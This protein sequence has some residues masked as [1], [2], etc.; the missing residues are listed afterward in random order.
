MTQR[1]EQDPSEKSDGGKADKH[2]SSNQGSGQAESLITRIERARRTMAEP[3]PSPRVIEGGLASDSQRHPASVEPKSAKPRLVEVTAGRQATSGPGD[4]FRLA[5][6]DTGE[7]FRFKTPMQYK[8]RGGGLALTLCL[9]LLILGGGFFYWNGWFDRALP[10]EYRPGQALPSELQ[11]QMILPEQARIDALRPAWLLPPEEN[12]FA[13]SRVRQTASM[14]DTTAAFEATD[15]DRDPGSERGAQPTV[16]QQAALPATL[17]LDEAE[18]IALKDLLA[19]LGLHVGPRDGALDATTREAI[20]A[21]EATAG[22]PVD[23]EASR[24]LLAELRAVAAATPKN[25]EQ[26]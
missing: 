5:H 11:A 1:M 4:Y 26:P 22:L 19:G 17:S 21:F 18:V 15:L 14:A 23:G 20:R 2:T 6:R 25:E 13:K 16:K 3:P 12:R 10:P 9:L 7:R 8:R 24:E